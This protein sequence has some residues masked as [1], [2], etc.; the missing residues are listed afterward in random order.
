MQKKTKGRLLAVFAASTLITSPI[1]STS[2]MAALNG[3]TPEQ[4]Q[5]YQHAVQEGPEALKGFMRAFPDSPLIPQIIRALSDQIGPQAAVQ[6]ALDA[7]VSPRP[8]SESPENC[9]RSVHAYRTGAKPTTP[10]VNGP[11]L[12]NQTLT[13]AYQGAQRPCSDGDS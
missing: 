12:V 9:S 6:A 2:L 13:G 10:L 4:T 5:A 11:L 8:C 7:G 1:M 3:A